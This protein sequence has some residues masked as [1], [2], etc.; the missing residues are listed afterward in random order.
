MSWDIVLL[1]EKMDF[2]MSNK[3][4]CIIGKR[5]EIIEKLVYLIP[6]ANF[7]DHSWGTLNRKSFSIEFSMGDTEMIDNIMLHVRGS[8]DSL[9]T[10]EAICDELQIYAYDCSGSMEEPLNFSNKK[11]TRQSF[12]NWQKYRNKVMKKGE[13][14]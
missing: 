8:D 4:P 12:E 14:K 10:I 13:H 7:Q 3:N 5:N 2:T 1:K 6:D 9:S 11:D